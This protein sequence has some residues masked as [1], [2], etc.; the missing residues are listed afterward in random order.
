MDFKR[1][2]TFL[3]ADPRWLS[4][5]AIASALAAP[6][7]ILTLLGPLASRGI[8]HSTLGRLAVSPLWTI[9]VSLIGVPVLGFALRIT[10]NV[11]DGVEAPLPSWDDFGGL[12][13]DGVR[14]WAVITVWSLPILFLKPVS[15]PFLSVGI[16]L[17][18]MFFQPAA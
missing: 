18:A 2:L 17:L 14:L 6:P 10:R 3:F 1:A 5:L 13:H 4:K 15:G 16:S 8:V 9:L 12:L 11:L 7:G